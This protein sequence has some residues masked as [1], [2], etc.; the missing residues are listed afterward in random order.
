MMN[1][2]TGNVYGLDLDDEPYLED[3]PDDG[4]PVGS[5]INVR[6]DLCN[7]TLTFGLNGNWND[8]PAFT[9]LPSNPWY[10]FVQLGRNGD[11]ITIIRE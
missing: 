6:L 2:Y 8:E 5:L 1:C 10:P 7:R 4:L 11:I 9:D 3:L